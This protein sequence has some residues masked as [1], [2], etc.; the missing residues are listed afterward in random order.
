[1]AVD[2]PLPGT[3]WD[4]MW[5]PLL[6][7]ALSMYLA[8]LAYR[9]TYVMHGGPPARQ[10]YAWQA[11]IGFSIAASFATSA[12]V[13]A[14]FGWAYR[15]LWIYELS[16]WPLLGSIAAMVVTT[17]YVGVRYWLSHTSFFS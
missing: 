13:L 1:M 17:L 15:L 12:A 3:Y 8:L 5:P 10:R 16:V 11:L 9:Y 4:W 14:H 6:S 7:V 2:K